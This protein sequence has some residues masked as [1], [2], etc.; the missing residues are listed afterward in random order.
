MLRRLAVPDDRPLTGG[1]ALLAERHG[2]VIAAVVLNSGQ[3]ATDA[4]ITASDAVRRLRQRRFQI[5][6]PQSSA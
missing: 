2:V 1:P 4:S 3:V 6:T 5:L